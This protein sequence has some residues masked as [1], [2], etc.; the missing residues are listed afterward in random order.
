MAEGNSPGNGSNVETD[1]SQ[2]AG[3]LPLKCVNGLLMLHTAGEWGFGV[4]EGT[5]GL[6]QRQRK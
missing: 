1:C 3:E 4:L 6:V 2:R 5:A